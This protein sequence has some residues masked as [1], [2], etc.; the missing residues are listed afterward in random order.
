M[1]GIMVGMDQ[2]DNYVGDEAR[3]QVS[4]HPDVTRR[5]DAEASVPS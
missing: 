4:T 2:Y 1:P 3:S 5:S